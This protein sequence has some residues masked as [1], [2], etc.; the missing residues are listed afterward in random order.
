MKTAE[1]FFRGIILCEN[2]ENL[3][4]IK[5][6]DPIQV[7]RMKKQANPDLFAEFLTTM[8]DSRRRL[9]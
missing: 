8:T 3:R 2:E 9:N 7:R 4:L 1:L 6:I 5:K